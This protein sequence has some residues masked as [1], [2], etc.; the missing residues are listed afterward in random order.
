[1]RFIIFF[2]TICAVYKG[3]LLL[4]FP[5]A[6][7]G[8]S[9]HNDVW[10]TNYLVTTKSILF[11][12]AFCYAKATADKKFNASRHSRMHVVLSF[13]KRAKKKD[14]TTCILEC[15]STCLS[16]SEQRSYSFAFFNEGMPMGH[17]CACTLTNT[18]HVDINHVMKY[19]LFSKTLCP[20]LGIHSS[21]CLF[22]WIRTRHLISISHYFFFTASFYET[23]TSS[24]SAQQWKTLGTA[25]TDSRDAVESAAS[26]PLTW[27][28]PHP[29]LPNIE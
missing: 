14:K 27:A 18:H 16:S 7:G 19:L 6:H 17:D 3:L 20:F 5:N 29:V 4:Y 1:M 15:M 9:V 13:F 2:F 24:V 25:H 21:I 8:S 10:T 23:T 26:V 28:R 12:S 22:V 11:I